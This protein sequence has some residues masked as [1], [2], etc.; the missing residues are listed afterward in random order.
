MEDPTY[1]AAKQIFLDAGSELRPA[2]TDELGV[3]PD[4]LRL[5]FDADGLA[6]AGLALAKAHVD[7]EGHDNELH[8]GHLDA[9]PEHRAV[10][11]PPW[12]RRASRTWTRAA[13]G[14][15]R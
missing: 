13:R 15:P 6:A 14:W 11:P 7:R 9:A 2:P 12:L 10:R 5:R 8:R 3:A 4:A 1:F